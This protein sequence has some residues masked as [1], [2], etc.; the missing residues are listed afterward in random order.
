MDIYAKVKY[1]NDIKRIEN[2]SADPHVFDIRWR[3]TTLCNYQCDFCIQGNR[4]E[5]LKQS[6]GESRQLRSSICG[7]V[8]RLIEDLKGYESVKVSLIGGVLTILPDLPEILERLALCRFPGSIRFEITTNFFRDSR[9]FCRLCDIIQKK[10]G[11]KKRALSVG[12]SYYS[13]YTDAEHFMEKLRTVCEYSGSGRHGKGFLG[14]LP[15]MR[16]NPVFFS[17]GIPIL[18][19]TDYEVLM[20]M[21][22]AAG[23]T[24]VS[25]VPIY[26]RNYDTHVS[27]ETMKKLSDHAGKSIRVTDENGR[28]F[29]YQ[30]IQALGAALG[31]RDSFCPQG[32]ICDAGIRSVWI[33]AF[34]NTRRCPAI[35]STMR[36]GSLLD[37]SFRL[38]EA[39]QICTSDHCSCSQFGKIE[40]IE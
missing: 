17:A 5:H 21:R 6:E 29:R 35:G 40:K 11:R 28:E 27:D 33:D 18:N 26:I 32:Y 39:P 31:D 3:V 30:N 9:Y 2:L 22:S 23:D 4:E 38:L 7:E 1:N 36:L 12:A 20:Q 10:A 37:G 34:G 13:A 19:D 14:K 16:K 25:I 24:A 15:G 8:I